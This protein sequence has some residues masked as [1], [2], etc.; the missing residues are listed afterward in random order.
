MIA[1]V[2][3]DP[4]DYAMH[5]DP[6]PVY[7][8]LRAEAPVYRNERLGFWVLSRHADVKAAFHDA[9]LFSNRNGISL[10]P[11]AFGP[12]AEKS[13]SFLAMDPPRHDRL[14]GLVSRGFTPRRVAELEGRIRAI[15]IEHLSACVG[16]AEWDVI[17]DFA[18]KLPMDV[19]SEL[20]GVPRDDR[21]ELRRWADLVVHR[22]P[23]VSG[24]PAAATAASRQ[25]MGYFAAMIP[26]RRARPGEDLTSALLVAEVDGERLTDAEI[27]GFLFLMVIAGSETTTKLIGNAMY[28]L[29]RNPSERA[30]LRADAG[31]VPRWVEE[32][33]RYD[34]STQA[35]GRVLTRD[36][37]LHG[38]RLRAGDWM[39]LLAVSYT[40]L[41][42]PTKRIV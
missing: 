13:A 23:G 38:Q 36:V 42:L 16:R 32:T 19:I 31:L 40:H 28:W 14:R 35:V 29:W 9:G 21:A 26:A 33:L 5:D 1:P 30:R 18:G 2:V 34:N 10:D 24:R 8:R 12:D 25:L 15:A 3:Y 6:Y 39:V 22:E 4:F 20:L 11:D 41:T 37:E 7:A 17:E 27:M